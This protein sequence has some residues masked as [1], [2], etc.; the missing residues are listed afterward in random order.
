MSYCHGFWNFSKIQ[1]KIM[2]IDGTSGTKIPP[3]AGG[4]NVCFPC[5]VMAGGGR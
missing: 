1:S 5:G 3:F 2:L 4:W